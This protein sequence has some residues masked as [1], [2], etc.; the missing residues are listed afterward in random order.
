MSLNNLVKRLQDVMR[1]DAGINGDA[2]RIEQIVWILFLKI[3]DAK[4]QEWEQIDDNYHSIL[5]DFLRWQNWAKDNKDGKAMTGDELLNFVNN[6]LFPALKN[7]PISAE[8]PMNQKIIRAAFE[9]NNNYMKNGILLRQVINIIDEINFEQYQERH[10]FGDI[11]ENILKSLQSAGN[12]GEF[13]T[14]RA[15]TDFM[16]KMIKPRL[17]EKIADFAC[18][19]G[20]F[21]TSALKELDKQNDSINDKNLLSNSVYG[22]EKKALPHLLCIT[23][24]LLHDID[25][26]N[27]HHDNAL[28]K[29][30]KD[31]TENDKFDVILMNPPYG[32][33]EIEQIK[34]NFPSAL[35]SSETADLFMSVIMYRLKKNGRVAIVLP[36]GF[37]FGTDNAKMAIKQK[38][39]SEMNLHTVIRLPHSVFAPYTS[40]TTNILFFDNTEP[41]K[42]T[43]FYRLDMPQGYKNFSKTKPMKLE[44][45]NEVM[46][47]WH[48]RQAIEIDGFDKARC[49]SY[50]E[51]ADR[52]FN[53]DLCGFPHEEEEILPPDELIANYQQKRTALNA[54]IDRI[55]GEITQILGIK[56]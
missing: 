18:G 51:I 5:P 4:E 46:E 40:I 37:L 16:A 14:P 48:N 24:L 52:Q 54:D 8:T 45:F 2:Q 17:G 31:Y 11:Y 29:P 10:A 3:Y 53:I 26:P 33:S 12:A 55:L 30:V 34:T 28:E 39:M 6:E 7:L 21:L 23:N 19:T 49:Y 38:L 32:G 1:N 41:T 22:I 50:Q 47:W 42:E 15:V 36:D 13:Y 56:L 25:N 44:H 43:W 20:G 27:V 35:R 9:D